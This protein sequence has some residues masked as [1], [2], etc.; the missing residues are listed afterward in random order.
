MSKIL[1]F[2]ATYN[3]ADNVASITTEIFSFC[4]NVNILFVD[5]SSTDKTGDIISTLVFKDPRVSLIQRPGKFGLGSAHKLAMKYAVAKNYDFLITM[6]ADFS[7]HPKYLPQFIDY[8]SDNDFV[9]GSRYMQG[10]L[11]DLGIFRKLISWAANFSARMM[12]QIPL[13][14]FTTAYRGFS[15]NLLKQINLD[16]IKSDGYSFF[17]ESLFYVNATTKKIIEFPIHL[18]VRRAGASKIAKLEIIKGMTNLVRLFIK[19]FTIKSE[20]NILGLQNKFRRDSCVNCSSTYLSELY[21]KRDPLGSHSS[22][23]KLTTSGHRFHD[24]IGVCLECNLIFNDTECTANQILGMY[25]DVID[26]NFYSYL[27]HARERT[28]SYNLKKIKSF[29]PPS[30]K[31]L[32]I[33]A[34][35]GVFMRTAKEMGYEVIGIEPSKWASNEAR[36]N[37]GDEVICGTLK[38]LREDANNFDVITMWDVFEHLSD[39]VGELKDIWLRLKPNGVL[40]LSTMNMVN[41]FPKIMKE[42]YPW[43]LD[44]HLFYFNPK[45]LTSMLNKSGFE[46][47][48]QKSYRHYI[49][50]EYLMYKLSSLG[51][52]GASLI[53]KLSKKSFISKW[54]VPVDFGDVETYV[55]KKIDKA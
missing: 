36:K 37:T 39:P 32:D 41:W 22:T 49:S 33:G 28:Y 20:N 26:E 45:T 34:Y 10:G 23:Y 29:L 53:G 6:D 25:S 42:A 24:K 15:V 17:V 43:I 44:K 47:V 14:E 55:C 38:D 54:L 9:I 7:H 46:L 2:L 1:V 21:P 4:P 5:D 19:K 12:L 52:P 35:C 51:I 18:E 16:Q 50:I 3:E 30:G 40:V 27:L 11:S 48:C 13:H 8:L 31:L